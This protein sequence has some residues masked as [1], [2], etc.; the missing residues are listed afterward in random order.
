[1]KIW[2]SILPLLLFC[3]CKKEKLDYTEIENAIN[4]DIVTFHE[5]EVPDELLEDIKNKRIILIGECHYIEEHCAFLFSLVSQL[6]KSGFNIVLN[7]HNESFGWIA[8]Y[9]TQGIIDTLPNKMYFFDNYMLKAIRSLNSTLPENKISY[10][11]FDINHWSTD[12]VTAILEMEKILGEQ[13]LFKAI[14][15]ISYGSPGYINE[16]NNI[17][18][19]LSNDQNTYK[20]NWGTEWYDRICEMTDIEINS[21]GL[22]ISNNIDDVNKR[23]EIMILLIEKKLENP[24]NK[25]IINCGSSHAQKTA[26]INSNMDRLGV[27][28]ASKYREEMYSIDVFGLSGQFKSNFAE[29]SVNFDLC[30]DFPGDNFTSFICKYSNSD[31]TYL[32]LNNPVFDN[33]NIDIVF[34]PGNTLQLSPYKHFDAYIT[35]PQVSII[36]SFNMYEIQ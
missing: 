34:P 10:T 5:N 11:Y 33:E 13:D 21:I 20:N 32:R 16:L 14:K 9:Y 28:L 15:N 6:Q 31:Y 7:E 4:R 30:S 12:F 19:N 18:N 8:E 27:Y 22:D 3:S 1:M 17:K 2:I 35:I 36:R 23:E 26:Y 24:S 25:I 29:P